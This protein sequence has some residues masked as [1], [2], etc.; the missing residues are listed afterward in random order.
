MYTNVKLLWKKSWRYQRGNQNLYIEEVQTKTMVERKMT[1]GSKHM[2]ANFR[3]LLIKDTFMSNFK[4]VDF[5][6]LYKNIIKIVVSEW[7]IVV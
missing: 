3:W 4:Y 2:D 6:F 7:M 5:E 1:K